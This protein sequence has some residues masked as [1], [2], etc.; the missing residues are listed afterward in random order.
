MKTREGVPEKQ[1]YGPAHP[2]ETHWVIS[3]RLSVLKSSGIIGYVTD[4]SSYCAVVSTGPTA[5]EACK[6]IGITLGDVIDIRPRF[7]VA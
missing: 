2:E 3:P 7:G 6:R 5:F 4:F 1:A